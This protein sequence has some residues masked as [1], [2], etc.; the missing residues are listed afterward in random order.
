MYST[1]DKEVEE[2]LNDEKY[3]HLIETMTRVKQQFSSQQV[4]L[5]NLVMRVNNLLET[6][7]RREEARKNGVTDGSSKHAKRS[8]MKDT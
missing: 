4:S 1:E 3:K 6:K 5:S 8:K 7:K 2:N